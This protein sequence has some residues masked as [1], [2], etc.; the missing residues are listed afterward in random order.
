M[1]PAWW[2]TT[3][4]QDLRQG[5]CRQLQPAGERANS[6]SVGSRLPDSQPFGLLMLEELQGELAAFVRHHDVGWI[7]RQ[8]VQAR[9]FLFDGDL[10]PRYTFREPNLHATPCPAGSCTWFVPNAENKPARGGSHADGACQRHRR[11][12]RGAGVR[13]AAGADPLP[14]RKSCLLRLPGG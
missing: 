2:R 6:F 3:R 7:V 10:R 8:G 11:P 5:T 13:G 14:R 4:P 1:P 12:L 9:S